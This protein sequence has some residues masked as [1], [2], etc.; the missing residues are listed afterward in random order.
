MLHISRSTSIYTSKL[1]LALSSQ[2]SKVL[3]ESERDSVSHAHTIAIAIATFSE[4]PHTILNLR[5]RTYQK[6]FWD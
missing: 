2:L 4:A 3:R 5:K 6:V 1:P